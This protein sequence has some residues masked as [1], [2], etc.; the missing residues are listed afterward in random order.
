MASVFKLGRDKGKKH[1][2]W[3]Y[4]YKDHSGKKTMK[5]G[6]TDKARTLQLAV[7]CEMEAQ[8][9]REGLID[10]EQE[11]LAK[12]KK[13][14]IDRHLEEF[15]NSLEAKENTK[16]HVKLAMSR[17]KRITKGCRFKTLGDLDATRVEIF[18]TKIRKAEGFG[19]RTYNHY[20]QAI[21]S[22]CNWLVSRRRLAS[23]P[24]VGIPRLNTNT[25]VRHQRR[26]LSDD[27]F[28]Q[29]V[30]S[31]ADSNK[32]IQC[33]TGEERARIYVLSYM[34]GLRRAEL[35]SLTAESFELDAE[36][37]TLTVQ[38]GASKHRR[39]DV[40]PLHPDLVPLVRVWIA[41]LE[42]GEVL[43]PKLAKRRT[44]L[45]VKKDLERVGIPYETK[46]GIADFHAAGRHSHIT[47]LLRS[48]VSVPH[49]M[50]LAR[51]S[52]VRMTMRYTHLGIAD[53]A[54]A[55]VNLPSAC[56]HIVSKSVLSSLPKS[57]EA[58]TSKHQG[59]GEATNVS[60]SPGA[61]YDTNVH[62]NAPPVTGEAKWRRR[63]SNPRPVI[64]PRK[65]L[66]V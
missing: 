36:Q 31:A 44:W 5:R 65:L 56:Q 47:G 58:R 64:S 18:M 19:P 62:K 7:K 28:V 34:T 59:E 40:L 6:F 55:L 14:D 3:Y 12:R 25:D 20:L 53:Q 9:R 27:E 43:F 49:A 60:D 51:H 39:K 35:G 46:D 38:A 8:M 24:V 15:Q 10:G 32:S 1:A 22:F 4:Q 21:E 33:Y 57:A 23:N 16:K 42:P 61:S 17:V 48:G 54:A 63:E 37:P 30:R 26:A 52:D 2:P 50:A 41:D 11:E 29:L 13:S 45:M 66:R